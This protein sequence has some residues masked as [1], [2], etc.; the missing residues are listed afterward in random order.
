[1]KASEVIE[2]LAR[3][4]AEHGDLECTVQD[5]LS[6]SDEVVA[7]EVTFSESYIYLR[8]TSKKQPHFYIST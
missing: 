8:G 3:G 4:I 2:Q 6:P 1:M 5:G 7:D